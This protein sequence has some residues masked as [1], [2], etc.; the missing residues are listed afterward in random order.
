MAGQDVI[1]QNSF[2][3]RAIDAFFDFEGLPIQREDIAEGHERTRFLD[4]LR[5][6]FVNEFDGTLLCLI[7]REVIAE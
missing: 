3:S 7:G 2:W 6:N 1:L 5:L 4:L